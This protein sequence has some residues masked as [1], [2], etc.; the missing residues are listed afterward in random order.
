MGPTSILSEEHQNIL[1]FINALIKE[2]NLIKSSNKIN[3]QFFERAIDFIK[4]YADKFHHAK[5]EDILFK[6]LT[7][8][9]GMHCNPVQQMIYEHNL[10]REFVKGLEAALKQNNKLKIVENALNYSDLLQ[11]HIFKEDNIL[12][13]M[14]NQVLPKKT[15]KSVL[16]K[17]KK[18]QPSKHHLAFIK[19]I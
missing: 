9:P 12:Y 19:T 18:I 6:E 7:N 17:F 16:E 14:A 8:N 4:N 3:K 13:P 15:Q 10:G 11:Q 1:K 5:E 2:S